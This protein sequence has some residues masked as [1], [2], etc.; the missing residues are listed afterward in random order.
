MNLATP[1]PERNLLLHSLADGEL[2]AANALAV[3][4]HLRGCGGCAAAYAGIVR[5]KKLLKN[6][7][8]RFRPP[9]AL[10]DRIRAAIA[11]EEDARAAPADAAGSSRLIRF[12]PRGVQLWHA[13]AAF[14]AVA[15]AASLMLFVAT[16]IETGGVDDQLVAAHVRSMLVTHL[17]DVASSD[18]HTVKPWFLGK[19]DFAPP[20]V[21]LAQEG[22]PL[23]GGRLDYIGG[24]VVPALVY[25]RHN[26]IINVFVWPAGK[27]QAPAENLDGYHVDSWSQGGFDYAA[28][29]DLNIAELGE[30]QRAFV[31]A[32]SS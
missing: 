4:E 16:P 19:L 30:F 10:Q 7:A 11:A 14:S 9:P 29:S 23:T 21:D 8:L 27:M 5:Q 24:K 17:T 15:L 12:K 28:V 20:V 32:A 3:E 1:C 13:S 26:H 31:K 2:D 6:E 25:R 18:Q 22:F